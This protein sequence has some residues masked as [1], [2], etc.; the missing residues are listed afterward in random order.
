MEGADEGLIE[1]G[2]RRLS[3]FHDQ[4]MDWVLET[5]RETH[6]RWH[7]QKDPASWIV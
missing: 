4:K 7:N 6:R 3:I 1:E 2:R 5:T